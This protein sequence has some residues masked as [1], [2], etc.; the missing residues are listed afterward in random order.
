MG[1]TQ[2]YGELEKR[3]QT[4]EKETAEHKK[5]NRMLEA[6]E[7][8]LSQIIA[9]SSIPTFV[10]DVNHMVTH[11]NSACENL[12]GLSSDEIVGTNNQWKAFYSKKRPV[13]ADIMLD[14]ASE[15][16][17]A[18]YYSGKYKR[19]DVAPGAYNAEDFFPDLGEDG[20]WLFFTAVP[21]KDNEGKVVGA[22][23]TLQDITEEKRVVRQNETMLRISQALHEHMDLEGLLDYICNEI[24]YFLGTE[25]AAV[26]FLEEE[27]EELYFIG[28][29]YED[30][31]KEKRVKEIRFS[32][33]DRRLPTYR[34][35][36][37]SS[38]LR[39]EPLRNDRPSQCGRPS[40]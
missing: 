34:C 8:Q 9:G 30:P 24:K 7:K 15:Q 23:E 14:Q 38:V 22:I 26:G 25:R 27:T 16:R 33:E 21:I 10:I 29:A 12:T 19:S 20:K 2:S 31:E 37:F 5:L 11:F 13:M 32:L 39:P 17:I 28:S 18:E 4:L 6:S 36:Q 40:A 35:V 1:L 3:I